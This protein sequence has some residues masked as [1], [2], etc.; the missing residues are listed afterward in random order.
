[1]K[2]IIKIIHDQKEGLNDIL[3]FSY[4]IIQNNYIKR[5]GEWKWQ[6]TYQEDSTENYLEKQDFSLLAQ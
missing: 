5:K 1:M 3:L 2:E 6:I 4:Y